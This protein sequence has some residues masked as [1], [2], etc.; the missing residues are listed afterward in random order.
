VNVWDG[1]RMTTYI[2]GVADTATMDRP[3][4][5]DTTSNNIALGH[6]E[7]NTGGGSSY[8]MRGRLDEMRVA[9]VARSAEWVL[10]QYQAAQGLTSTWETGL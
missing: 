4:T 10:A 1:S 2:N 6:G 7:T 8:P 9:N 5:I 3:G